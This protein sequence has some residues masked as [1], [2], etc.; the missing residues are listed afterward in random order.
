MFLVF[1]LREGCSCA[2]ARRGVC[3]LGVTAVPVR[4][5]VRVER[6]RRHRGALDVVVR[7]GRAA[8]L[9]DLR[10]LAAVASASRQLS[11]FLVLLIRR[12]RKFGV[13]DLLDFSVDLV[14]FVELTFFAR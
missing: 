11:G 13:R 3:L 9:A 4:R 6:R 8:L 2:V 10:R 1:I 12:L 5:G 7:G 14:F